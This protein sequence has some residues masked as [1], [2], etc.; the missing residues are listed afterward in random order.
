MTVTSLK[1]SILTTFSALDAIP[2][3]SVAQQLYETEALIVIL[4]MRLAGAS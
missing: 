1:L 2:K 4:Q 3:L